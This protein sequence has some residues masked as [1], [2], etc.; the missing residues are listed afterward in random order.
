MHFTRPGFIVID[1]HHD[2]RSVDVIDHSAAQRLHC[3]PRVHG[4]RTLDAGT[5][6]RLFRTQTGHRLALHVGAH[7]GTVGVVMLEEGNQRSSDRNDLA[8]RNVHVLHACRFG[9]NRF[10]FLATGHQFVGQHARFAKLGVGLGDDVGALFDRREELDLIGHLAADHRAVGGFEKA[11]LVGPSIQGQRVDQA[12][13]R[14][15]RRLDRTDTSIVRGMHVAHFEAG[16]LACQAT[17]AQ[18]RNT[19]LVGDLGER[20]GLIHEL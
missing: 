12:D 18:G 5:D 1:A 7:Q 13:V 3:R 6:Q 10:T 15:F 11:V 19:A 8:R 9:K 17:R 4:H 20:V 2:P 16:A 14:A